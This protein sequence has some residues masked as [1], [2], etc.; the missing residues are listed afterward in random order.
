MD[1]WSYIRT[2]MHIHAGGGWEGSDAATAATAA[3]V[4]LARQGGAGAKGAGGEGAGAKGAGGEAAGG[5]AAGA[6][7]TAAAFGAE[8]NL[9]RG[10][11]WRNYRFLSALFSFYTSLGNDVVHLALNQWT[12]VRGSRSHTQGQGQG[13]THRVRAPLLLVTHGHTWSHMVTHGHTWLH[14]VRVR[15]FVYQ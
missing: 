15:A 5:E 8:L 6:K 4:S 3:A 7:G 2:C 1:I 9:L 11:F 10:V 13:R 14:M 12:Q